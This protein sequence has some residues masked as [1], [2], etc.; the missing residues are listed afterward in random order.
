MVLSRVRRPS[1]GVYRRVFRAQSAPASVSALIPLKAGLSEPLEMEFDIT[2]EYH[3]IWVLIQGYFKMAAGCTQSDF[4]R[5]GPA[6][7]LTPP[8]G[9]CHHTNFFQ[10][11]KED[12]YE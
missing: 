8:I 4:N 5:N 2:T 9:C 1:G 12:S 10:V 6:R 3:Y 11:K 7:V